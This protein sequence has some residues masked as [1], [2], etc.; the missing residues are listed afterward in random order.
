MEIQGAWGSECEQDVI[1]KH[2][3]RVIKRFFA[4]KGMEKSPGKQVKNNRNVSGLIP[5]RKRNSDGPVSCEKEK[6]NLNW[7]RTTRKKSLTYTLN[8]YKIESELMLKNIFNKIGKVYV[9]SNDRYVTDKYNNYVLKQFWLDCFVSDQKLLSLLM[10]PSV[11]KSYFDFACFL[12]AFAEVKNFF[13]RNSN[14]ESRRLH[15]N[16]SFTIQ[17]ML[18]IA[19]LVYYSVV[20]FYLDQDLDR[21]GLTTALMLAE[22]KPKFQV[23][24]FVDKLFKSHPKNNATIIS[25]LEFYQIILSPSFAN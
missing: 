3:V 23:E 22:N 13:V 21:E 16:D 15:N 9:D 4:N 2:G 24:A 8:P 10:K 1:R 18:C 25:F 20:R 7:K 5:L 14:K 11:N 6:L 12:Q 19:Y 17:K